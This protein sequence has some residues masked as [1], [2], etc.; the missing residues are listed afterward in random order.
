MVGVEGRLFTDDRVVAE[1]V[2]LAMD[3]F[4]RLRGLL[5]L[6]ELPPGECL[7]LNPCQQVHTV[8]MRFPIDVVFLDKE[9][10][11]VGIVKDMKPGR[12]SPFFKKAKMAV[13]FMAGSLG[14]I[15]IGQKFTLEVLTYARRREAVDGL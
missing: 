5:G 7:I 1:K 6:K 13:E 8:G 10:R 2:W 3:F 4:S 9:W 11:V 12:I 15:S 14:S